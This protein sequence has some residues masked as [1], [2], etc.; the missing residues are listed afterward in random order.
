MESCSRKSTA[1]EL[2]LNTGQPL[3]LVSPL[4]PF[5]EFSA[6]VRVVVVGGGGGAPAA[7]DP[8]GR[9]GRGHE[10]VE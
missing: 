4:N 1:M 6:G 7:G 8:G 2:C 9:G 10:P 5:F 3:P